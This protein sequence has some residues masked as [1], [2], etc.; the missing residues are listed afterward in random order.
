MGVHDNSSCCRYRHSITGRSF[1]LLNSRSPCK[2]VALNGSQTK[3]QVDYNVG[4]GRDF[5]L[6]RE[7][8]VQ[9]D[10][11]DAFEEYGYALDIRVGHHAPMWNNLIHVGSTRNLDSLHIPRPFVEPDDKTMVKTWNNVY[12]RLRNFPYNTPVALIISHWEHFPSLSER[13][14]AKTVSIEITIF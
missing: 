13:E 12:N 7:D 8:Y 9:C 14:I 5:R 3:T 11:I 6:N 1:V 10:P 2:A 4:Y